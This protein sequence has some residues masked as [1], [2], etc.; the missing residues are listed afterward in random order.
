[1]ELH[2][3]V[4]LQYKLLLLPVDK[5]CVFQACMEMMACYQ[6]GG[7]CGTVV[8]LSGSSSSPLPPYCG[9]HHVWV[10]S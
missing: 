10:S 7:N 3:K 1:M 4:N 6:R 8:R 5:V 9:S 2:P